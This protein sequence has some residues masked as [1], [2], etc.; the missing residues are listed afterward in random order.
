MA[1][2]GGFFPGAIKYGHRKF[3]T[4]MPPPP[5]KKIN[6]V[7]LFLGMG[8]AA[9]VALAAEVPRLRDRHEARGPVV[10]PPWQWAAIALLAVTKNS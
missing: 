10:G 4:L 5:P 1:W 2:E 9:R 3:E 8:C 7:L 6:N